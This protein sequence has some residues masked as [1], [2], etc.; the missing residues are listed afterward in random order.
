[1]MRLEDLHRAL[2]P[3]RRRVQLMIGRAV[4]AVVDDSTKAQSLQI[5]MLAD[6]VHDGAE[7]FQEYGFTSVP[8]A[9]AEGIVAFVGGLRSHGIIIAVEDRRYRL[10]GLQSGEVALYD[11]QSQAITLKRDGIRVVSPFK[12]E[13]E[14]PHVL[15][16][17]DN[18]ELGGTGGKAVARVGDAVSGGII[19]GGSSK[20]KAA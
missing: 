12:I 15:V 14:A 8:H 4:I 17:S 5:T 16:T 13:C 2:A 3:L 7:R 9:G 20:V 6:E 10:T 11:D 18:V 19:T 1:M